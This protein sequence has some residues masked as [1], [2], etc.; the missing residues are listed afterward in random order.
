MMFISTCLR[1]WCAPQLQWLRN[2]Y[3]RVSAFAS[4]HHT[5]LIWGFSILYKFALDIMYVWGVSPVY[6]Y[7]GLTYGPSAAR[8]VIASFF[9]FAL[10]AYL[11]KDERSTPFFLL[12][13]QFTYILAPM[14]TIYALKDYDQVNV[15]P[16]ISFVFFC[17]MLQVYI[18]RRP[19]RDRT[20]AIT[21]VRNYVTVMLGVL[22]I[23]AVLIP[24]LYNGFLFFKYFD[25][26]DINSVYL[27]RNE[28]TYPMGYG[29]LCD[30]CARA[31]LPFA[32]LVLIEKKKYLPAIAAAAF[33]IVLFMETGRKFYLFVLVPVFFVY[34]C[35]KTGHLLKLMY[36]GMSVVCLVC[37]LLYRFDMHSGSFAVVL[38]VMVGVR[39]LLGVADNKLLFYECFSQYPKIYFSDGQVGK[40]FGLTNLYKYGSGQIAYRFDRGLFGSNSCTGYW[41]E[42]YAQLGF[43]G[44]FL[45]AVLFAVI[46]R[47]LA[48]YDKKGCFA[49]ITGLF[50]V[51]IIAICDNALF[52]VLLSG[53]MLVAYLLIFIYFGESRNEVS[54][55]IQRL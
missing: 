10:F 45:M 23:C 29:Y 8:Y 44:I 31:I 55:G 32:F 38:M 3:Q 46:I 13:L 21:G 42:A 26:H 6:S 1:G 36:A 54:H 15:L 40:L 24:L 49:V 7:A 34:L 16:Y 30:W 43:L 51:Y 39:A 37:T 14:F 47:V 5:S 53:G 28:A 25:I 52:T 20:I 33:Q 2:A 50:S 17:A 12:N 11:P 9:Y 4:A 19:S 22:V 35:A 18:V 41:G 48:S 27:I